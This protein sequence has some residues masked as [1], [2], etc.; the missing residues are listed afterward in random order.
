M[1]DLAIGFAFIV[2]SAIPSLFVLAW[3]RLRNLE[4]LERAE[5]SQRIARKMAF[6]AQSEIVGG[7]LQLAAC[8][9]VLEEAMRERDH[10]RAQV[11]HLAG[12]VVDLERR[13]RE[14]RLMARTWLTRTIISRKVSEN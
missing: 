12:K 2:S 11:A 9:A 1:S 6:A 4:A 14:E 13:R 5:R 3:R 7:R 10:Y 8:R